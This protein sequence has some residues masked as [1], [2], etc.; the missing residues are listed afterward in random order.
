MIE[1][2]IRT[3]LASITD[4]QVYPLKLPDPD[5]EGVTFLR[6]S[7]PEVGSGLARSCLV[8]VRFQITIYLLNDYTRAVQLEKKIWQAWQGIIHGNLEGYP[9]QC[10]ERDGIQQSATPLTNN[11]TQYAIIR[12]YI[13]TISE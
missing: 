6:V 2:A 11:S 7:D 3:S 1:Q 4:L 9:V 8:A 5:Q 12:D 10:I 13:L